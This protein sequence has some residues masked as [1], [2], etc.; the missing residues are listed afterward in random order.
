MSWNTS[1][2]N[3][4]TFIA[5]LQSE[6]VTCCANLGEFAFSITEDNWKK[7]KVLGKKIIANS[8]FLCKI[9]N[10]T[11]FTCHSGGSLQFSLHLELWMCLSKHCVCVTNFSAAFLFLFNPVQTFE[12]WLSNNQ[13]S[14]VAQTCKMCLYICDIFCIFNH[15][16]TKFSLP[17]CSLI[18]SVEFFFIWF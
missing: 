6:D 10:N 3:I 1:N 5:F 2:L 12:Q 13:E 16:G 14:L 8:F 18:F 17:S 15:P 7:C 11:L 9:H 4:F